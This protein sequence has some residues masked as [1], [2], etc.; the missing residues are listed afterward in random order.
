MNGLKGAPAVSPS[1]Q[2]QDEP[3][4]REPRLARRSPFTPA[5]KLCPKCLSP[6]QES[7]GI[8]GWLV[9]MSYYCPKCGYHGTMFLEQE[10]EGS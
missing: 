10:K 8:G 3:G 9:P 6:L 4:E 7:G 2:P 1:L 5:R